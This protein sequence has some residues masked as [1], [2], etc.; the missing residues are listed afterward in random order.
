[1]SLDERTAINQMQRGDIRGLDALMRAY[2]VQA[3]R[4]AYLV[5]HDLPLAEDIVQSAFIRAYERIGQYDSSRPFGPWFMRSVVNSA[6]TAASRRK[7][8]V[9]LV[10]A[11]SVDAFGADEFADPESGPEAR[12]LGAE[13][14]AEVWQ[15]I[16]SLPPSQRAAIVLRYYLELPE[17]ETAERLGIPAGTVKSRLSTARG[18]LRTVFGSQDPTNHD[19]QPVSSSRSTTHG[20]L[21]EEAER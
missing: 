9:P 12:M 8:H 20:E 18:R 14:R 15:A 2:Q 1:M 7:R 5:T 11:G 19:Y 17:A 4:A 10:G 16:D 13:T 21:D 6:V 3:I